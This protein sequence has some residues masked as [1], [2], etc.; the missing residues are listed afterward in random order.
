MRTTFYGVI[1]T[2]LGIYRG[3]AEVNTIEEIEKLLPKGLFYF[4]EYDDSSNIT[5]AFDCY[6]NYY[7][8]KE[9]T[10]SESQLP[11]EKQLSMISFIESTLSVH[12]YDD[13]KLSAYKFIKYYGIYAIEFE[14]RML[15]V[16][17]SD[18]EYHIYCKG[19]EVA[20]YSYYKC[21]NG[22]S[23]AWLYLLWENNIITKAFEGEA[24]IFQ[25]F[26]D[27]Y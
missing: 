3:T 26:I 4:F 13:D 24:E 9:F 8:V 17:K 11:T 20:H 6:G 10:M 27:K 1:D 22:H 18:D 23:T 5:A 12:Y 25:Y 21:E 15:C 2:E 7:K 16:V 14:S 19:E